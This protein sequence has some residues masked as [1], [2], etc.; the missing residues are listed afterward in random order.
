MPSQLLVAVSCEWAAAVRLLSPVAAAVSPWPAPAAAAAAEG[1]V[2]AATFAADAFGADGGPLAPRA[3]AHRLVAT[4]LV[5]VWQAVVAAALPSVPFAD[6]SQP[7]WRSLANDVRARSCT[8]CAAALRVQPARPQRPRRRTPPKAATNCA[9]AKT[10]A[11][12]RP[13]SLLEWARLKKHAP[14][15]YARALWRIVRIVRISHISHMDGWSDGWSW[16][17]KKPSGVMAR[18]VYAHLLFSDVHTK[19]QQ[20]TTLRAS[21][22]S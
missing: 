15:T 17:R 11:A 1:P 20:W 8:R 13:P 14:C 19:S 5:V 10:R 9:V 18:I 6:Q 16:R 22:R 4:L 7:S 2:W 3:A 21:R 12:R